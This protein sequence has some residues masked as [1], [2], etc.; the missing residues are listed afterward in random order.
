MDI[1]MECGHSANAEH[2]LED[3]TKIPSCAICMCDKIVED[4][5]DLT[6]RKARCDYFGQTFRH[7]GRMVTCHGET[8]SKYSLAF[9]EHRP[10]RPFDKYYCGCYGWN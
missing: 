1:F 8:N 5:P 3:G 9:F 7:S 2:V 10:T 4:K 6:G